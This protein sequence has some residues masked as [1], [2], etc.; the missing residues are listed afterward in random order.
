MMLADSG[1]A[2]FISGAPDARWNNTDLRNLRNVK[3]SDFEA[4][5]VAP[6]MIDPHSGQARQGV[7]P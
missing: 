4:V 3:G 6:L 1:S 7:A 2:W 5:D